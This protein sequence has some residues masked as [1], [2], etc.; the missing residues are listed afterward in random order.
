MATGAATQTTPVGD[1]QI[2]VP[3]AGGPCRVVGINPANGVKQTWL[4]APKKMGQILAAMEEEGEDKPQ[5]WLDLLGATNPGIALQYHKDL[6]RILLSFPERVKTVSQDYTRYAHG[7][8]RVT[9]HQVE[10][11]LPPTLWHMAFEGR[12]GRLT[13]AHL[14]GCTTQVRSVRDTSPVLALPYGNTHDPLGAICWGTVSTAHL[15]AEDPLAVDNLF[16]ATGFNDHIT[17]LHL[18]RNPGTNAPF[19]S[20]R[21][22]TMWLRQHPRTLCPIVPGTLT[23]AAA[24]KRIMAGRE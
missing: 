15:R 18:F 16:F 3:A 23:F 1:L 14:L 10:L 22:W 9:K 8:E 12:T 7:D 13:A 11:A 24:L 5:E 19:P 2:T 4:I 21:D 17:R 20:Y 6:T